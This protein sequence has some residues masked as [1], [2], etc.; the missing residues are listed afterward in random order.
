MGTPEFAIP[1]LRAVLAKGHEIVVV[2]SQPPKPSGRGQQVQKSPVQLVAEENG[3]NVR[4]PRTLRDDAEQKIF[5]DY[6]LDV[7]VVA[8]Y[9][10]I[11]PTPVLASPRFGCLNI[12]ASLLPRWRGAAPIQRAL[13]AGDTE[14]GV[15]I[16][17]MDA[18][19]DTGDMLLHESTPITP[20]TSAGQLHD[21]LSVIGAKLIV[22]ALE[23]LVE[24]RLKPQPQ[25]IQGIT[26]AAKLSRDDGGIAWAK[27]AAEIERQVRA[28]QPWPGSF[29]LLGNEPIKVLVSELITHKNGAPG[30]LLDENFT[31]ACGHQ[32]LRL[33]T[34][35]RAGKNPTDGASF[36]RGLRWTVGHK[37]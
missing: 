20:T 25:P 9:G 27:P 19:L 8:A 28:L 2:Y 31:V 32:A 33:V 21:Q 35:Q 36:L 7:A 16:M 26:Y 30:T 11:L 1:A 37:L 34:V 5:R 13:L 6:Q 17:Q 23:D 3:L 4:T 15:T 10:L 14:T 29:F 12:H 24:N 22:R 18:G